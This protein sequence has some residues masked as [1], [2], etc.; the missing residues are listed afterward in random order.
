MYYPIIIILL[1][2]CIW[3]HALCLTR[4]PDR[5]NCSRARARSAAQSPSI[6]ARFM[7]NYTRFIGH[8][9]VVELLYSKIMAETYQLPTLEYWISLA[10]F[11]NVSNAA[12]L[13]C[14]ASS[15][16]IEAVLLDPS[17]VSTY[18]QINMLARVVLHIQNFSW[19]YS[20]TTCSV[21]VEF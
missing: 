8:A 12:K 3:A 15:G 5:E 7:F 11:T 6:F 20:Y 21:H 17:L 18:H 9:L 4:S 13:R 1:I 19:F 14:D 2:L 16:K 10:L